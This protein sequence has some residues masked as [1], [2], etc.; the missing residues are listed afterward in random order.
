L[1]SSNTILKDVDSA[2]AGTAMLISPPIS[3]HAKKFDIL[4]YNETWFSVN[5]EDDL[6]EVITDSILNELRQL[7][8]CCFI[9]NFAEG[10][11]QVSG[12]SEESCHGAILKL[13][14][15]QKYYVRSL[16]VTSVIAEFL[17]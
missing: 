14:N 3:S 16:S 5:H 9:T 11:I 4:E 10:Q 8:G 15:I 7:T 17:N 12:T 6:S 1:N 13:D 2:E